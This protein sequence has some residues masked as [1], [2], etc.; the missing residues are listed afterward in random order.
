MCPYGKVIYSTLPA[1]GS[2]SPFPSPGACGPQRLALPQKSQC[3]LIKS[4]LR[5]ADYIAIL[6]MLKFCVKIKLLDLLCLGTKL[7]M[8]YRHNKNKFLTK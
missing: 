8:T 7:A 6:F 5:I 2:T 3:S 4:S 1:T